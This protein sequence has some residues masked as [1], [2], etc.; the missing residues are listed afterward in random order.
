[1]RKPGRHDTVQ[2]ILQA[3]D[4][5]ALLDWL[6]HRA[7]AMHRHGWLMVHAGVLPQW[8]TA[9]TMALA[10]EVEAGAART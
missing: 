1:M 10:A 8:S 6:R 4:R 2:D 9:Q 5:E 7:M 3:P